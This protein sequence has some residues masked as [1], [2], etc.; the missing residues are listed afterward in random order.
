MRRRAPFYRNP[1]RLSVVALTSHW[2]AYPECTS[3]Y[4]VKFNQL[5]LVQYLFIFQI[6]RISAY[7]YNITNLQLFK[8]DPL[9][10][11]RI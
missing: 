11:G 10:R 3:G 5:H 2:R 7:V 4:Y 6:L 9:I 8:V 1:D